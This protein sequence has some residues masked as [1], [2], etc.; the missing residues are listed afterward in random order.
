MEGEAQ[1]PLHGPAAVGALVDAAADHLPL[2]PVDAGLAAGDPA[3][4][5]AAQAAPVE[6]LGD[7]PLA[8]ALAVVALVVVELLQDGVHLEQVHRPS[9]RD[10]GHPLGSEPGRARSVS[11]LLPAARH[12]ERRG[13]PGVHQDSV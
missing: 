11:Y 1:L 7:L 10:S 2:G 13:H 3:G 12:S 6:V 9:D 4:Q 8:D 5:V